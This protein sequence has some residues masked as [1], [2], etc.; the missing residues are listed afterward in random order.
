MVQKSILGHI[1]RC[2]SACALLLAFG[3]HAAEQEAGTG[4]NAATSDVQTLPPWSLREP[5]TETVIFRGVVS[6][7]KTGVAQ[8]STAYITNSS[9]LV[10]A[11]LLVHGAISAATGATDRSQTTSAQAEANKVLVPYQ[12]TLA[13]YRTVELMESV[14]QRAALDERAGSSIPLPGMQWRT[15]SHPV[16]S[17]TQDQTAWVL[18]NTI[19]VFMTNGTKADYEKTIKIVSTP[20]NDSDPVTYWTAENGIRLRQMAIDLMT[21]SIRLATSAAAGK[22][23]AGAA[24]SPKTFRYKEGAV[25]R[26]E[27]AT[28]VQHQCERA[29]LLTLRGTL[30]SVPIVRALNDCHQAAAG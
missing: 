7:D 9:G 18:E 13:A 17:I 22:L 5:A 26:T 6:L 23:L 30:I 27:R 11:A 12:A 4:P 25:E 21:N 10:L 15:E 2:T 19:S 20:I 3:A 24:E 28:L 14:R 8:P 1:R 16:F 29:V